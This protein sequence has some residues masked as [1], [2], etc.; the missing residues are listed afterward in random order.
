MSGPQGFGVF[1]QLA[2]RYIGPVGNRVS[3]V[4]G[5]PGD[6]LVY[7]AGAA[8]GGIFKT[9]D[10]GTHWR[11][12]FDAPA[13]ALDGGDPPA[14]VSSIGA[15]A[16]SPSHPNVVWAGTG[17]SW[18]RGPISIGNGIYRSIDGGEHWTHVGL[19]DAGRFSRV[20][21]HPTNPDVV[22][23][24]AV[25]SCYKPSSCRGVF[26]TTDGG[27]TWKSALF[28]DEETGCSDLALDPN[29]PS[30]LYA[31][32]WQFKLRSW[33]RVSGGPGSG[34]YKSID[35]GERWEELTN[36]LPTG[37]R[38]PDG[39]PHPVGKISVGVARSDSNFVYANIETGD[40]VPTWDFPHPANGQL[41]R[42][43][44]AGASWKVLSFNRSIN[45]RPAYYTRNEVSPDDKYLVYFFGPELV[46]TA[47]G[48]VTAAEG[49]TV[50]DAG[51]ATL[52][53]I[54]YPYA[55]GVDHHD[56]WIDPTNGDRMAVASDL[57]VSISQNRGKTWYKI[58]LPISQMY[59]VSVDDEIPYNVYGNCQ[60]LIGVWGPS[61]ARIPYDLAQGD[62]SPGRIPRGSWTSGGNGECG[63]TIPDPGNPDLVWSSGASDGPNGGTVALVDRRTGQWRDVTVRPSFTTGSAPEDVEYRFH[64]HHPLAV[65]PHPHPAG[66]ELPRRV[67]AGSQYVHATEDHGQSWREISPE[68]TGHDE[69]FLQSSGG[70]TADNLGVRMAYTLSAL[71]ESPLEPGVLWVGT[72]DQRVWIGRRSTGEWQWQELDL[73]PIVD[74]GLLPEARPGAWGQVSCVAPSRHEPGKAYVTFDFHEVG[75]PGP[76]PYAGSAATAPYIFRVSEC[77]ARWEGIT[78]GIPHSVASYVHWLAEHPRRPGLLFAGT[79]NALYV[80][81]DDGG[82]WQVLPGLPPAPIS[83]IVVQ[84]HFEDLVVS[85][86]GRG[87]WIFDDITPLGQLAEVGEEEV[88]LFEQTRPVYR[89]QIITPVNYIPHDNDPTIGMD[90]ESPAPINFFLKSPAGSATLTIS[91]ADGKPIRRISIAGAD[92]VS[93]INRVWW[94]LSSD[95]STVIELRTNPPDQKLTRYCPS[96]IRP[97]NNPVVGN[98]L[99]WLVPPGEYRLRLEVDLGARTVSKDGTIRVLRDPNARPDLGD[100]AYRVVI[101]EQTALSRAIRSMLSAVA[102]DINGIEFVCFQIQQLREWLGDPAALRL[103]EGV[104]GE[105]RTIEDRL[106]QRN[107]TGNGEDLARFPAR[108]VTNLVYLGGLVATGDYRPTDS[109]RAQFQKLEAEAGRQHE[110]LTR[111]L[112]RIEGEVNPEL[113]RLG[114]PI[115]L[116]D[117]PESDPCEL[118]AT[119][120]AF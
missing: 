67:Y 6:P 35:G 73:G 89:F 57:G 15:L 56:A 90:P 3:A 80:S 26:K 38:A 88:H 102:G 117:P 109:Q 104:D 1:G 20:V 70:L 24:G 100:D 62:L 7:Y 86:F 71:A 84:P 10:G 91:E 63:Y 40:G 43:T 19:G 59:Q 34:L 75:F 99:T 21:V 37:E 58:Q 113:Q 85:T 107:I 50:T 81:F 119:G 115:L 65:S 12:V 51:G 93:G 47:P 18:I 17:E 106:V 79:E 25:G 114:A 64:W 9:T 82:R 68:L 2:P 23:A 32:M 66:P 78:D 29:D 46:A 112:E 30:V 48:G 87:F 76:E 72:G 69:R 105:L 42:S 53:V 61:N 55:P 83:G 108:L 16:V 28:L 44:D 36:G 14:Q 101:A 96:G 13:A 31:G 4:V 95:P 118:F 74:Q 11:A 33:I 22:W 45:A 41:W 49:E 97:F 27:K 98:S 39:K 8:A 60:D 103:L 52:T 120:P 116:L 94:D 110:A 54:G 111:A 77:G 92:T 5:V